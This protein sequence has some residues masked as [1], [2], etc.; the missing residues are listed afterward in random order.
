MRP[1]SF[2]LFEGTARVGHAA[3]ASLL[4]SLPSSYRYLLP[5]IKMALSCHAAAVCGESL[6]QKLVQP[7]RSQDLVEKEAKAR[8][9][10]CKRTVRRDRAVQ[11]YNA[12][13]VFDE[14]AATILLCK[15]RKNP[16]KGLYNFVGGKIEENEDGLHA[17][18]RELEEE[19]GI[20]REDILLTHLMDFTYPLSPCYLEVYVGKLNKSVQVHGDEN[21]LL[22]S[23]LDKNFFDPTQY[24]GE[25]NMGHILMQ[26]D[27][28]RDELLR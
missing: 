28:Y 19:T 9:N 18:Y 7:K 22:W 5:P 6:Y 12:I 10:L 26:V 23:T 27:L 20:T 2:L 8:Y 15:R 1:G 21:T 17:A 16:Y 24:A 4:G 11:G 25:G 14:T 13:V 3:T